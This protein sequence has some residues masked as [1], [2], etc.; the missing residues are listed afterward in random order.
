LAHASDRLREDHAFIL[1]LVQETDRVLHFAH[2]S[3]RRDK[4]I[5]LAAMARS[6]GTISD[7][8]DSFDFGMEFEFLCNFAAEIRSVVEYSD[9]LPT[10]FAA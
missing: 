10:C 2:F 8:F 5:L 6:G 7:C 9:S 4:K 1:S 3:V